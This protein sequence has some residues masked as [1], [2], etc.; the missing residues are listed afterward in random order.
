MVAGQVTAKLGGQLG[1]TRAWTVLRE[2][3][4]AASEVWLC[5]GPANG[6]SHIDLLAHAVMENHLHLVIRLRPDV[7]A[8]WS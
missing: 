1:S 3:L 2:R 6:P 8:G 4:I 7:V 5:R